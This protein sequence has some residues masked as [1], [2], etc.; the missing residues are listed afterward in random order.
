MLA[1][2]SRGIGS[3]WTS[4]HLRYEKEAAVILGIPDTITQA[5]LIPAAY[6]TGDDFKPAER[7]SAKKLIYWNQWRETR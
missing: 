1:L 4:L 2:R 7:L 5:A 3:A 6:Y